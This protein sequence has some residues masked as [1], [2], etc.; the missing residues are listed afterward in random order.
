[1][2][3]KILIPANF[4]C[5]DLKSH[6]NPRVN[7]HRVYNACQNP[8]P[9]S[10][11][12]ARQFLGAWRGEPN[13][14]DHWRKVAPI[15]WNTKFFSRGFWRISPRLGRGLAARARRKTQGFWQRRC[16]PCDYLPL[17]LGPPPVL[18]S[19]RYGEKVAHCR[20]PLPI[21]RGRCQSIEN[22]EKTIFFPQTLSRTS[23]LPFNS[24]VRKEEILYLSQPIHSHV[25]DVPLVILGESDCVHILS[26]THSLQ[27]DQQRWIRSG[28]ARSHGRGLKTPRCCCSS[29]STEVAVPGPGSQ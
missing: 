17:N 8:P 20:H 18:P 29:T 25:S 4:A 3:H 23:C 28:R 12:Q 1:M 11:R 2:A 26:D 21:G 7:N 10:G 15:G 22:R 24:L 9:S 27:A 19:P 13:P 16:T 6:L 14:C 5:V